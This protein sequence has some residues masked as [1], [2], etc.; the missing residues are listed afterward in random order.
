M[1]FRHVMLKKVSLFQ[2]DDYV[3]VAR[4]V[5][6]GYIVAFEPLANAD[7]V[8]H[9]LLFGCTE[10]AYRSG[11]W[12]GGATCGAGVSH[13]L[14]AWARNAPNL[15]LPRNVAFSVGH[16]SDGIRYIVLQVHYAQP[17]AGDVK[18]YSGVTLQM[19]QKRPENLAAVLLFVSG[20]PIPPGKNQVQI[21]VSCEYDQ[22][23]ELHPFAFR[24][25]THA[26]GRVVSAYYKHDEHWTKIGA[27][28]PL[29]P[30]L[31]E[32]I[33]TSPVIKKGDLMAATCRFDSHEKREMTPMGSMGSNEMCNFYMMFYWD[34]AKENPFPWGA[35]CSGQ[36]RAV[37]ADFYD[38]PFGVIEDGAFTSVDGVK[39]GQVAGLSFMGDNL[40]IFHRGGRAWDQNTFDEYNVL[41]DKTPINEDVILIVDFSGKQPRI[42]R[43][44][45][46]NKF[47]LPHGIYMDRDGFLYTTDVGSHTVAKWRIRGNG[48]LSAV[49]VESLDLELVW[50]SGKRFVP[51]GD[52]FHFCK[53]TGIVK[54]DEGVFVSDGYCNSKVVQLDTATGARKYEFGIPGN[55]PS[56]FNLPHDVVTTPTGGH[57]LVADRENGRV[58]ELSTRGDFIMDWS[59][60]VMSNIYSVDAHFEYVYMIP[61]RTGRESGGIRAF[62][63]R[64]GTGLIE[65]SFS[66]TSRPFGQPHVIRVSPNGQNIYVGD[67]ANGNPTLWKFRVNY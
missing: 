7:R 10:P 21:N 26:M 45:G 23:I 38:Y 66:P 9:I 15:V 17:F 16:E 50:E 8:H 67:I 11:F 63:G 5:T 18:D 57:L 58:Q 48:K 64:A 25:H 29:W 54:T 12:K 51:D 42:L 19:T 56:Q 37:C 24:T 2:N 59:S 3:A 13:I 44:L 28:N 22:D 31:F 55:G 65:F 53:P 40:I 49:S 30:Q 47:Y 34:A 62:V 46:R 43:K 33:T 41:R 61:G 39:L 4:E 27:R 1:G 32:M 36:E 14:Y 35:A 20:E 6:Q 60:S 52:K